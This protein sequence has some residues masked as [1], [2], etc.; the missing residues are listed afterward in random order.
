MRLNDVA[1]SGSREGDRRDPNAGRLSRQREPLPTSVAGLPDLPSTYDRALD[2][3]LA[4][5]H[6]SLDPAARR[7]ID[8]HARLLLA[9]TAAINLTSV[10]EPAEVARRH[11]IDSLTALP[12][13]RSLDADRLVDLG[14]GGGY[15][16]LPL[17][18]A[19]PASEVQLVESVA[20]KARFL[21]MAVSAIGLEG[22]ATVVAERAEA[23]G[24]RAEQR[25][26]WSV[27]TAR[28]VGDLVE[29]VELAFPLLRVG[30]RLIAWKRGNIAAELSLARRLLPSFGGGQIEVLPAGAADLPDHLLVVV[31]KR[32]PTP[33]VFPRDPGVRKRRPG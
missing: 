30:G 3:G 5:L 33:D 27:V 12:L 20:K 2:A 16:G 28:A 17:A 23:L 9:W 7:A 14:S 26:R 6:L 10:R 32:S 29:L 25:A 15:P 1:G 13:L 4:G 11:V 18:V 22:R 8:D 24:R 31:T 21:A 19:L